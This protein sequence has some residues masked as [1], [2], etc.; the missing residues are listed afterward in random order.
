MRISG[1]GRESPDQPSSTS[2]PEGFTRV[3][4]VGPRGIIPPSLSRS[5]VSPQPRPVTGSSRPR[6]ETELPS[7]SWVSESTTMQSPAGP[8]GT[9]SLPHSGGGLGRPMS[10]RSLSGETMRLGSRSLSNAEEME[11]HKEISNAKDVWIVKQMVFRPKLM[12]LLTSLLP[13]I[14]SVVAFT[15]PVK[16]DTGVDSIRIRDHPVAETED[17]AQSAYRETREFWNEYLMD[18]GSFTFR[19][20]LQ[21]ASDASRVG[22]GPLAPEEG[23][24]LATPLASGGADGGRH[25]LQTGPTY[26][27]R[28]AALNLPENV[29]RRRLIKWRLNLV[30]SMKNGTNIFTNEAVRRIRDMENSIVTQPRYKDFCLED[31]S[32]PINARRCNPPN[33]LINYF[34]PSPA[35]AG[36]ATK[37]G[38]IYDGDGDVQQPIPA[39]TLKLGELGLYWYT[40]QSFQPARFQAEAIRSDFTFAR[41]VG[42]PSN[43]RDWSDRTGSQE[44]EYEAW[45][46]GL[47][48]HLKGLGE[49]GIRVNFGG[50]FITEHE[51]K[52]EL[53]KDISYAAIGLVLVTLYLWW[54][55]GSAFITT[56]GLFEILISYPVSYFMYRVVMGVEYTSMLLFLSLFIIMGI[57]VDDI[58]VFF[59]TFQL[60]EKYGEEIDLVTRLSFTYRKAGGAMLVTSFTSAAAFGANVV[61]AIPSIRVFGLFLGIM[62]C[63]NY[64]LVVT[65]FPSCLSWHLQWPCN[66]RAIDRSGEPGEPG[67]GNSRRGGCCPTLPSVNFCPASLKD[68]NIWE[69]YANVLRRG[70]YVLV[71]AFV[72]LA[73]GMMVTAVGLEAADD[74]PRFFPDHHNVQVFLKYAESEF[75]S[76]SACLECYQQYS[77]G[78][79]VDPDAVQAA[80]DAALSGGGGISGGGGGPT[81]APVPAGPVVV[82]P[83]TTLPPTPAPTAFTGQLGPPSRIDTLAPDFAT[84]N[85][86]T[87]V[88]GA[89]SSNGYELTNFEV[90]SR[91]RNQIFSFCL[92]QGWASKVYLTGPR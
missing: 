89:P 62:V 2:P 60:T 80:I 90:S 77:D 70:R 78:D 19:R 86:V 17:A 68:D 84:E 34:Y 11:L 71:A 74:V 20:R 24:S 9:S 15:Y 44:R 16:I 18:M 23:A 46:T 53:Y 13:I 75:N 39:V 48:S 76:N 7:A 58:F 14:L 91:P 47:Y 31:P 52:Q 54:H 38:V 63:V 28:R 88:W 66:L 85:S 65:W 87:F 1:R 72:A 92:F 26:S 43:Y 51:I 25:L 81:M 56:V 30:F 50:E 3:V 73:V 59:D 45:V 36:E 32:A 49:D 27:L 41:P 67:D 82:V 33:S 12:I 42:G 29:A 79:E 55:T 8:E 10:V 5:S 35:P 37:D 64:L 6:S 69:K 61:S 40:D 21:G 83:G 57:G 4:A 22:Q